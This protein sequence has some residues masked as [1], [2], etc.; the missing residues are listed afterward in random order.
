MRVPH[1]LS[2]PR[3]PLEDGLRCSVVLVCH[4][5]GKRGQALSVADTQVDSRVGDQQLNDDAVLVADGH[6]DRCSSF[7]I[8]QGQDMI[9]MSR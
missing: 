8:L 3:L 5:T 4:G 6:V 7:C 1:L 9:S 2:S